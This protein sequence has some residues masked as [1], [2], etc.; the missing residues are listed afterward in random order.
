M[1]ADYSQMLVLLDEGASW[2]GPAPGLLAHW[3]AMEVPRGTESVPLRVE[4]DAG[5]LRQ[6]Y[7]DWVH[8]LGD[9]QISGSGIREHLHLD[10]KASYWWLTLIAEKSPMK[11]PGI[12]EVLKLRALERLYCSRGCRGLVL[13]SANG[14]LH[15]VLSGWCRRLGHA[16]EWRRLPRHGVRG[17]RE[18]LRG[19]PH[20]VRAVA[21]LLQF[22]WQRLRRVSSGGEFP[23]GGGQAAMVT[24]F[25]NIDRGLAE[26]GVF[27]S[28]YWGKLHQVLGQGPWRLNWIWIFAPSD[29]CS[30]AEALELRRRFAQ[31]SGGRAR[32]FF[33]E[34]FLDGGGLLRVLGLYLRLC[35]CRLSLRTIRRAFRFPGS[36]LDFWPLLARDWH[37]SLSGWAAMENCLYK[38]A[39]EALAAKLPRQEFSLYA[40]E[41]QAWERALNAA[42]KGAGH[43]GLIGFQHV[44][45]RYLDLRSF[46][47]PRSYALGAEAPPLPDFLAVGGRKDQELFG[48]DGISRPESGAGRGPAVF[49]S[50][51]TLPS[52]PVGGAG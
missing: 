16:Y 21:Y 45:L 15:R 30:F 51:A 32:Y 27:A 2:G 43:G 35:R 24:Y 49:E 3:A 12:Y 29:E 9:H 8:E 50:G 23:A 17:L 46:E 40:W 34:E 20:P 22:W 7:L 33:W 14:M 25:P 41:N 18:R 13:C 38:V 42:W 37:N 19:A 26:K 28:R 52:P 5:R 31:Q 4:Q 44:S 36:S 48:A 6:E 47:A 11:S 1:G 39:F 10:G